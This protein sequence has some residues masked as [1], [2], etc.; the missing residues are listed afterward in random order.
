MVQGRESEHNWAAR[1]RSV[2]QIRGMLKGDAHVRYLD[3]FLVGLKGGI[4]DA[5]LKAVRLAHIRTCLS[6]SAFG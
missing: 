6:N 2:I 3:T 1:E 5:T 4:L